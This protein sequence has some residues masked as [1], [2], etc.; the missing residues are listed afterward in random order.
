MEGLTRQ[1]GKYSS[2]C[3]IWK[4]EFSVHRTGMMKTSLGLS[5][6]YC[7]LS[8]G[9]ESVRKGLL[10]HKRLHSSILC[11]C[12][13][14]S[15]IGLRTLVQAVVLFFPL[16]SCDGGICPLEAQVRPVV[17][18]RTYRISNN[19]Q[20]V[21]TFN[22]SYQA[23]SVLYQ[24]PRNKYLGCFVPNHRAIKVLQFLCFCQAECP[25]CSSYVLRLQGTPLCFHQHPHCEREHE[26][27]WD[28]VKENIKV[29]E[30]LS[31]STNW[32]CFLMEQAKRGGSLLWKWPDLWE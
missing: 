30:H 31:W 10:W 28:V 25:A 13:S 14:L 8:V 32:S 27:E 23:T 19:N 17:C 18:F 16:F 7:L 26:A 24:W 22:L 29:I 2:G 5:P 1:S 3:K 12:L 20:K 4:W 11:K 15:N 21:V 9:V 6:G